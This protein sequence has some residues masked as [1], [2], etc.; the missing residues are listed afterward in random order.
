[1]PALLP[2]GAESSRAVECGA[3]HRFGSGAEMAARDL[4]GSEGTRRARSKAPHSG[5]LQIW[6]PNSLWSFRLSQ[7]PLGAGKALVLNAFRVLNL[8]TMRGALALQI[9]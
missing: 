6:T 5:A 8:T 3:L 1:V 7:H 9:W 2:I 4:E